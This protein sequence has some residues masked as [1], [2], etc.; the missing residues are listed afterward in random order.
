MI[1]VHIPFNGT[2]INPML[3]A[4]VSPVALCP[5]FNAPGYYFVT[6]TC[7]GSTFQ[8]ILRASPEGMDK[9]EQTIN[10]KRHDFIERLSMA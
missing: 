9:A 8:S 6:T 2:A 10:K 1:L 3:V 4:T 5:S 7:D